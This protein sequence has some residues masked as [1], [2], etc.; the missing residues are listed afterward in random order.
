M[1][2]INKEENLYRELNLSNRYSNSKDYL[3]KLKE[4][5]Y[6]PNDVEKDEG[7]KKSLISIL[8]NKFDNFIITEDN[9][10]KMILIFYR[11][12]ANIPVIIMGERGCGKTSLILKLNQLLNN[13]EISLRIININPDINDND[14]YNSMKRINNEAKNIKE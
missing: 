11:I 7:D 6:L 5:L 10:K 12:K 9:F 4:V 2:F 14:I 8:N 1:I 3:Q 13:G